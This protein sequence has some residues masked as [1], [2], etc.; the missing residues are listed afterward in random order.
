MPGHPV[1]YTGAID[2]VQQIARTNGIKG[3]YRGIAPALMKAIPAVSIG[4]GAFEVSK[5]VMLHFNL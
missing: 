1:I 2:C 4:Y 5:I 3:F